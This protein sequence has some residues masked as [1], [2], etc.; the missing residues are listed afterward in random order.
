MVALWVRFGVRLGL[1]QTPALIQIPKNKKKN[2]T[3]VPVLCV[4]RAFN[5]CQCLQKAEFKTKTTPNGHHSVAVWVK[6]G[7]KID[8]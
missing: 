3:G 2:R 4:L 1:G 8:Y 6:F 7:V 5:Y